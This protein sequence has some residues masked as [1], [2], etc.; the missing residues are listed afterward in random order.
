MNRADQIAF[1]QNGYEIATRGSGAVN[2]DSSKGVFVALTALGDIT[3]TTGTVVES[4]F[5]GSRPTATI[6]EGVTIFG[7]F[8][9]VEIDGDA[10]DQCIAYYG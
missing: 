7:R 5:S 4:G 6:P 9:A 2:A 10:G 1:G 3:L 8:T